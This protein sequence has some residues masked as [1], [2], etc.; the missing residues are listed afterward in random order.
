MT[1][2]MTTE[3]T[4]IERLRSALRRIRD[5]DWQEEGVSP[6]EIAAEALGEGGPFPDGRR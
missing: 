6:R 1:M 3:P 4:A 5:D 2:T